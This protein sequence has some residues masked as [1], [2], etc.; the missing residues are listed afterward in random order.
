MT[1]ARRLSRSLSQERLHSQAFKER[2]YHRASAQVEHI[3]LEDVTLH[4]QLPEK[5]T[6]A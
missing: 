5:G 4:S 6:D 3:R 2:L 1:G